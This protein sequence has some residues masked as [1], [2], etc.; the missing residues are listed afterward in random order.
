MRSIAAIAMLAL[1]LVLAGGGVVLSRI[2]RV[3]A[4]QRA[5]EARVRLVE[6]RIELVRATI[7]HRDVKPPNVDPLVEVCVRRTDA[8]RSAIFALVRTG[9][10]SMVG[11]PSWGWAAWR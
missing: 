9:N 7:A 4:E 8:L 10:A 1:V 11:D 5:T 3:R 6:A 2:D